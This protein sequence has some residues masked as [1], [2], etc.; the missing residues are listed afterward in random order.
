MKNP[1]D[2]EIRGVVR[3]NDGMQA[4]YVASDPKA[5]YTLI[6]PKADLAKYNPA[7]VELTR[8]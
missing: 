5:S 1:Y 2:I 6:N 8:L 4:H 3:S 7:R